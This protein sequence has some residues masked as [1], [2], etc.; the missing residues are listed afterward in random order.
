MRPARRVSE[1]IFLLQVHWILAGT[2]SAATDSLSAQNTISAAPLAATPAGR[3]ASDLAATTAP[4]W[5]PPSAL[6]RRRMWERIVLLPQRIATLPLSAV[7]WAAEH[8]LTAVEPYAYTIHRAAPGDTSQTR[9][10]MAISPSRFDERTPF[11]GQIEA[12]S[13]LLKGRADL[14]V[15]HTASTRH[16]HDTAVQLPGLLTFDYHYRWRPRDLFYGVGMRTFEDDVTTFGTGVHQGRAILAYAWNR[17]SGGRPR[18]NLV[19]WIGPRTLVTRRGHEPGD[20]SIE[21]G[22]PDVV[23][24]TLDRRLLHAT[25]GVRMVR[26]WRVGTPHWGT[27]WRAV[28]ETERFDVAKGVLAAGFSGARGAQF[29]RST[30]L[31]ET[32][33]SFMHD[34]RS[35]RLLG[36]FVDTGLSGGR[37]RMAVIDLPSL[38]GDAGLGGFRPGRFH[39]LDL[40]HARFTYVF[41][42]LQ[43][44]EAEMHVESGAVLGDL[45]HDFQIDRMEQSWG[46]SVRPRSRYQLLGSLGFDFSRESTRLRWMIGNPDP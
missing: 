21:L 38:G 37:D 30:I 7:G 28:M 33:I 4:P 11:C 43:K 15:A 36:R 46:F 12:R 17:E 6:P 34:P 1:V 18:S 24:E 5:N 41:P 16:Y 13:T 39:D 45:W 44:V 29:T 27:G 35:I 14:V 26:D 23:S 10:R 19:G 32:G 25:Y 2:A 20:P 9:F 31:L 8:A 40:I 22:F 42:L 3:A